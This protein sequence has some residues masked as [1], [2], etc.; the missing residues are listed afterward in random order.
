M[1][2]VIKTTIFI[3]FGLAACLASDVKGQNFGG[4][5]KAENEKFRSRSK[6]SKK[7]ER[8]LVDILMLR[9][10]AQH[11]SGKEN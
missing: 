4:I 2:K 11:A 5:W 6:S 10:P 7:A 1:K 3:A 9:F 8:L